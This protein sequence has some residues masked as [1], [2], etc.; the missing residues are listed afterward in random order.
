MIQRDIELQKI[1]ILNNNF[2]SFLNLTYPILAGFFIGNLILFLTLRYQALISYQIY[3]VALI[4]LALCVIIL[5]LLIRKIHQKH[6]IFISKL[7]QKIENDGMFTKEYRQKCFDAINRNYYRIERIINDMYDVSKIKRG[8]FTYNFEETSIEDMIVTTI[9]DLQKLVEKK[10]LVISFIK[11]TKKESSVAKIDPDRISQVFRNLIEN[12]VKYTN[13][14]EGEGEIV[15]TLGENVNEY[16]ISVADSGIG[17]DS[18]EL[19]QVFDQ[20]KLANK[21]AIDNKGLA[22]GLFISKT[23]VESHD[24]RIWVN[25]K[26]K[27]K[28]STFYFTIPKSN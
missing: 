19:H 14:G 17:I 18:N 25:S 5:L 20:F 21:T 12:A 1:K 2:Q 22:L 10:G 16:V 9:T 4:S 15:L 3:V 8:L 23:I 11:E 26:G 28:G 24:G 27:G 6:L 7:L 13:E